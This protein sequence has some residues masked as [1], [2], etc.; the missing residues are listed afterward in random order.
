MIE[1]GEMS[2]N[3]DE[4]MDRLAIHFEKEYKIELK[5]KTAMA[6]PMI[7]SVVAVA[8]VVFLLIGVMPTFVGMYAESGIELPV[9]TKFFIN[10]SNF[11]ISKWYIILIAIFIIA[12]IIR[13]LLKNDDFV[14]AIDNFKLRVPIFKSINQNVATSRFTRTLSTLLGS[15]VSLLKALEIVSK[16]TGNKYIENKLIGVRNDVKKGIH[17]STPLQ[18]ANIF[19]P[20]VYSMVKIGEDSGTLEEILDKTANFYD[21]EV[22]NSVQ[23]LTT[24]LEPL[25]IVVMAVLIGFIMLAIVMPMFDMVS[26]VG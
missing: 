1:A 4:I 22:E 15:G 13:F 3:L 24:M 23:R 10:M 18:R 2:G 26:V 19:P 9:M 21:D 6:Y 5:V 11:M 7:L 16:V 12:Y 8:V 25:M 17:L 14:L 20:M